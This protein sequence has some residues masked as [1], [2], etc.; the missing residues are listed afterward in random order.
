MMALLVLGLG[1][2]LISAP[3]NLNGLIVNNTSP[4]SVEILSIWYRCLSNSII[5]S[6]VMFPELKF[7]KSSYS[8]IMTVCL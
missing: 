3:T 4:T 7:N 5:S 8:A 2:N 1:Y 6:S